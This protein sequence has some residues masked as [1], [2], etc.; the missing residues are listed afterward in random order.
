MGTREQILIV[1]DDPSVG[2]LAGPWLE[3]A[4]LSPHFVGSGEAALAALEGFIPSVVLLDLELPGIGGLDVL[5]VIAA[6][7]RNVPVIVLTAHREAEVAVECMKAGAY[8]YLVK[9]LDE[10]KLLSTVANA[11]RHRNLSLTVE[12]LRRQAAG[13]GL[14]GALDGAVDRA[15]SADVAVLL[16]GPRSPL[17][18]TVARAIHQRSSRAG[19]PF[20]SVRAGALAPEVQLAELG[21]AGRAFAAAEGGTLLVEDP[22]T[23]VPAAQGALATASAAAARARQGGGEAPVFRL[24]AATEV[25]LGARS[26]V[27]A[28][29]ADLFLR[30]SVIEIP[31]QSEPSTD[32]APRADPLSLAET[33]RRAILDALDR[34]RGNRAAAARELGIGRATLYRRIKEH[35]IE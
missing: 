22:E 2:L 3:A 5:R 25:D 34:T 21:D 23:L 29:R 11:L 35:D 27:G 26:R 32:P 10:P 15:A 4:G 12:S 18:Q 24:V 19:G 17:R 28:F 20:V 33:E 1:D 16:R 8:D 31:I 14:G 6:R 7:N 30:L 13:T 9:P